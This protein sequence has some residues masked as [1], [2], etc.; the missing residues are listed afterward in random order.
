MFSGFDINEKI[1]ISQF[2]SMFE[3]SF[4]EG[5]S[6][7][8]EYHNFWECVYVV[9]GSI[10]A[11][12]DERI[13][14]LKSG[15]LIFH[16]PMELHKFYIDTA[17]GAHLF[18]FSFSADGEL[19]EKLKNAVFTL[20]DEQNTLI[21][22]FLNYLR[23]KSAVSTSEKASINHIMLF[24]KF[25]TLPQ[26]AA[27]YLYILFLALSE[28]KHFA[29]VSTST[30]AMIFKNA[31]TYMNNRICENPSVSEIAEYC[32]VSI[33]SL[34]RIFDKFAGISIHKYFVRLKINA[35]SSLLESGKGITEAAEFLGFEDRSYFSKVYKR[36][37]GK[38]PSEFKKACL[39]Q[40][41]QPSL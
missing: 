34:K 10:T 1:K 19:C 6:F 41:V 37:T 36:E 26:T 3:Q 40:K 39:S 29:P 12:G 2:Y 24:R 38:A 15:D 28:Q 17:N 9:S 27:S 25:P 14:N 11:S 7:P 13:Y 30:D 33:T 21:G 22:S 8:G 18:I 20:S 16:K 23:K 5:F 32:L 31:V 4:E 35:A